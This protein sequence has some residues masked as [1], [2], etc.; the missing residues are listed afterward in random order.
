MITAGL[1]VF[2]LAVMLGMGFG[3]ARCMLASR[4]ALLFEV[5]ALGILFGCGFLSLF[6]FCGGFFFH[7]KALLAVVTLLSCVV[8]AVTWKRSHGLN[9]RS[10]PLSPVW[11]ILLSLQVIFITWQT[12]AVSVHSD[13]LMIWEFKARL[14][15]LNGGVIPI[16]Y[17]S[18][19][20]RTWSHQDY[21]LMIPMLETWIYQW[22]G[23]CNQT[24]VKVLFPFFYLA[25][26]LLLISGDHR[27]KAEA[28]RGAVAA[29]LMGFVPA[30]TLVQGGAASGW[31]DFPLAVIYL[32]AVIYLL[33]FLQSGVR[34][35]LWICA[36]LSAGLPWTKNE[37]IILWGFLMLA[38]VV[39]GWIYKIRALLLAACVP[40]L[41]V[42]G[43]WKCFVLSVHAPRLKDFIPVSF[44]SIF[45]NM[46]CVMV[47]ALSAPKQI[48]DFERWS[49]LW[50]CTMIAFLFLSRMR[51]N[52]EILFF[53]WLIFV[54][55]IVFCGVYPFSSW[56]DYRLHFVTSFPRLLI[57]I[58]LVAL[59]AIGLSIPTMSSKPAG[60]Q[61]T[62]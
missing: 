24:L 31:G 16:D 52:R 18:D 29:F 48:L 53:F 51:R 41:A 62:K 15:F 55:V 23:D 2:A 45:A 47:I 17:F 8:A 27:L 34:S 42:I 4:E 19:P 57:D 1:I 58:A 6:Q 46:D 44:E 32:A 54:P 10:I 59:F 37:G 5:S 50:P 28:W 49:L 43:G 9:L 20:S 35:S 38:M 12:L 21:P 56:P 22:I 3:I 40:G 33:D 11:L 39:I 60:E 36:L 30:L 14:A 7:G 61:A 25:A 26:V 13:G